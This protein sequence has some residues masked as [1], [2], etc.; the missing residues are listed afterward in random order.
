MATPPPPPELTPWTQRAYDRLIE[1][2]GP[3]AANLTTA[4]NRTLIWLAGWDV[5]DNMVNILRKARGV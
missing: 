4:E 2:M 5:T 1:A 3:G